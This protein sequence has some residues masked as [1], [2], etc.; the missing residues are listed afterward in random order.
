MKNFPDGLIAVVKRDCRTCSM[1]QPVIT[2]LAGCQTP[3][4]VFSQDDP[5]F[6]SGVTKV[7]DDTELAYSYQL[8][9][10]VVPTLMRV[11]NG[12]EIN[13]II[14]WDR[15]EW[16]EFT[17]IADLGQDLP[18]QRPGCGARNMEPEIAAELA[19]RYQTP[20][21]KA[22]RIELAPQE[23]DLEACFERGWTDGLPVVPPTEK[24]VGRMLQGS[25]RATDEI[26]GIIPPNQVPCTVAKVA[27]NAVMAGCKPEYLPVVLAAVEAACMDAFCMHGLLATTYFSGP[28]VIVNG[29]IAKA[30]GMNAGM[31]V[32]G[33]G[34]RANATI[35]RTLQL[36]IRNIGGGRPGGVD[37]ATFGN[38]GKYSFCFAED[39]EG[40]P[41]EPLSVERGFKEGAS[42]ATLFAGDGVQAI[43]DQRSRTP[44]SLSRTYANSLKTVAHS[45]IFMVA[46]AVLVVSPEHARIFRRAGW[47]KQRLRQEIDEVL[48]THGSE[49]IRG[50][51][52][53]AEGMPETFAEVDLTKFRPG[54]L[55]IVH[56]GGKAGMFSAIIGGWV[57]SGPIG[58][59]SVTKEITL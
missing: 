10:E 7:I 43:M 41:W 49:L 13:R 1:I 28:V 6:F 25:Q 9:I 48:K 37:R 57:A 51:Q 30:I 32:L 36:V 46:D 45:K 53:I 22:R 11:E 40:S 35:G 5:D 56:A 14:G 52:D 54:G 19:F 47:T 39:E 26:V 3:L 16:Q 24:R 59:Q 4:T 42:T 55:H 21:L 20:A 58:S 34:N 31:N 27:I 23:D 8:N 50:A 2:K 12:R 17:G 33:Q 38:P 15:K 44:E 29:P 18:E